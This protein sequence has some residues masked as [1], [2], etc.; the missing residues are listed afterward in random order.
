MN[1]SIFSGKWQQFTGAVTARWGYVTGDPL[2]VTTGRHRQMVGGLHAACGQA[3]ED[4]ARQIDAVHRRSGA[5]YA[6]TGISP[7]VRTAA[8]RGSA[9][10]R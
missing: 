3:R 1:S 6:K 5:L 8:R 4:I 2:R 10:L 7:V 9:L